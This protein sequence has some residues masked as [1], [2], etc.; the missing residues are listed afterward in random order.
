VGVPVATAT[1]G[2]A[3]GALGGMAVARRRRVKVLGIPLP[4][5]RNGLTGISKEIG[6]AGKQ[7]GKLASEVRA[8][9]EK[10]GEVGKALS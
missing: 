5:T 6:K 9:R 1:I 3:A 4:G 8:T 2:V 7:L 10:A